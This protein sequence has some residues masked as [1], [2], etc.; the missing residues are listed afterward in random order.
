MASG[1]RVYVVNIDLETISK[2]YKGKQYKNLVITKI[3]AVSKTGA[4]RVMAWP[5]DITGDA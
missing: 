3:L 5:F 2:Q 4:K 1:D